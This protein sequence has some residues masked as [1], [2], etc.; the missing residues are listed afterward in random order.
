MKLES[1]RIARPI[2]LLLKIHL[3]WGVILLAPFN[4]SAGSPS[5][6]IA[7]EQI[8]SINLHAF[9]IRNS[10][11][12]TS[13][14]LSDQSLHWSI[15]QN[16]DRGMA[17]ALNIKGIYY[18]NRNKW[19]TAKQYYFS[20]LKLRE[21]IGDKAFIAQQLLNI[22][23][24]YRNLYQVD[25]ALIYYQK[26]LN[27]EQELENHKRVNAISANI[28]I[29]YKNI[30][31]YDK[32]LDI[33]YKTLEF[34]E[35]YG[36]QHS[37]ARAIFRI[38]TV[39]EQIGD[40]N[41]A[42]HQYAKAISTFQ[43]SGASKDLASC[44]NNIANVFLAEGELDSAQFYYSASVTIR[45]DLELV[46]D[47]AGSYIN[48]AHIELLREHFA[49]AESHVQKARDLFMSAGNNFGIAESHY[50]EGEIANGK[51]EVERAYAA[52]LK[53]YDL[54][55][56]SHVSSIH[57]N[58]L[59]KLAHLSSIR[60]DYKS[61]YH[62]STLQSAQL[63]TLSKKIL[64]AERK[65]RAQNSKI[66]KLEQQQVAKAQKQKRARLKT[67]L[68]LVTSILLL[69]LLVIL[70]LFQRSRIKQ[71]ESLTEKSKQIDRLIQ[72][73]G[74]KLITGMVQGQALERQKISTEL[75][76]HLA[77]MLATTKF[78]LECLIEESFVDERVSEQ[79]QKSIQQIG[80]ACE[81]IRNISHG[82]SDEMVLK[83]GFQQA[84]EDLVEKINST[85]KLKLEFLSSVRHIRF[86]EEFEIEVF[87]LTQDLLSNVL[88]HSQASNGT[89]QYIKNNELFTIL[90]EDDGIGF[91]ELKKKSALGMGISSVKQRVDERNGSIEIDSSVGKG[92]TVII[93][94]PIP[95]TKKT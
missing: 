70:I 63:D 77:T 12:K 65:I 76:G 66:F 26:A 44:Y 93:E 34:Q 51:G 78:Q 43:T 72:E 85:Q 6:S 41:R 13:L 52:Y 80:D 68:Y 53:C 3:L 82:L 57:L 23:N 69:C 49:I 58:V 20:S 17:I 54:L 89:V 56:P 64:L 40:L 92:T 84:L 27:I 39:H 79:L 33:L 31:E 42:K 37:E 95:N 2:I 32:A 9:R 81:E 91:S 24:L 22:G 60:A 83:Y 14:A 62:Y 45:K 71:R 73:H 48:L 8:D 11:P 21:K 86:D 50:I 47:L 5:D 38:A 74:M 7:I 4:C 87:R 19:D 55:E 15:D 35:Q 75:H 94:L 30:G 1:K 67:T 88:K 29:A 36:D 25:T 28:A 59:E 10:D 61:A 46:S 18:K 90:V 16:Y